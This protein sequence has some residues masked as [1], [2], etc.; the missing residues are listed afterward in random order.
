MTPDFDVFDDI[1]EQLD[2]LYPKPEWAIRQ[3]M[4]ETG[5]VEDVCKCGI[6]HPNSKHLAEIE[7]EGMVGWG[8]HGCC[9][10][11]KEKKDV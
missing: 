1:K 9:G 3:L 6:G 4:R 8:V 7:A 11:C 5:L 2:K 10:C